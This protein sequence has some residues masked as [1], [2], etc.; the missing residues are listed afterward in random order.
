MHSSNGLYINKFKTKVCNG[1]AVLHMVLTFALGMCNE[2][3]Y[4][5]N[6]SNNDVLVI[7]EDDNGQGLVI[8]ARAVA[9]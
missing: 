7:R 2:T 9:M 1:N 6:H 8:M 5:Q 4:S 3:I